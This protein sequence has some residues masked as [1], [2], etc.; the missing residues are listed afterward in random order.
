MSNSN[1]NRKIS[2][3]NYHHQHCTKVYESNDLMIMLRKNQLKKYASKMSKI[4]SVRKH[5]N[6][7]YHPNN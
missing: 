4:H 3:P 1:V 5:V 7:P 6:N 2:N